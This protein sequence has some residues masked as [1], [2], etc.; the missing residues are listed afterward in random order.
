[1]K[2]EGPSAALAVAGW[3]ARSVRERVAGQ[4]ALT[5]DVE[6]YFQVEALAGRITRAS[7]DSRECRI[8]S[9][10][11]RV[12]DLC[13]ERGAKGTF[14][15]LGWIA[16]RYKA[17]VREI[18]SEGHELASHGH[19]HLRA[20]RVGPD[21]FARDIT[22][23]KQVLE[24]ISGQP[25]LGYRAPCFSISQPNLWALEAIRDAGYRYSS[26]IYPIRHDA[27]GLP[28][29][30]RHAFRP[31]AYDDFLE[32]PVT[33]LRLL[34]GNWPCGG[35]GYFR[36]LPFFWSLMALD[37]VSQRERRPCVFYFHP[38]EMDPGQPRIRSLP[39]KSHLR[40][41]TNL[42]GMEERVRKLLEHFSW[43]RM[44]AIFPVVAGHG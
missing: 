35:G 34:G 29:A 14:F 31:F 24:D 20:D 19:D 13:R 42:G 16:R 37:H 44:D 7:W 6:D 30:P 21:V 39:L 8:E 36:L 41:Y 38:W 2:A 22:E 18:V 25:V 5:V 32:I 43:N 15:T 26:S 10:L 27:Y 33:S 11:R 28:S 17:L 4:N 3:H 9:S 23:A 12:L 1:M 40:H